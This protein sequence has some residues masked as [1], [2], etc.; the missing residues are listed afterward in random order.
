MANNTQQTDT[1]IIHAK[2]ISILS[3]LDKC[4]I[5]DISAIISNIVYTQY[6]QYDGV[7]TWCRDYYN[8]M[9][10]FPDEQYINIQFQNML[11]VQKPAFHKNYTQE[12]LKVLQA[13]ATT[14]RSYH[15]MVQG[16][17][18]EAANLINKY[19]AGTTKKE[20]QTA[21]SI[22][23]RYRILRKEMRGGAKSGIED[24]DEVIRY[25]MKKTLNVFVAPSS[26]F[27][28]TLAV[29][30]CYNMLVEQGLNVVYLTLEDNSDFI[31]YNFLCR[32]SYE[33]GIPFS[34]EEVKKYL[35]EENRLDDFDKVGIDFDNQIKGKLRIVSSE[36]IGDFNPM[37]IINMLNKI[38]DEIGNIDV[39]VVDHFNIMNDPI[40]GMQLR[41]PEL[42]AYYVR[43]MTHLA[44]TYDGK[45]FVLIGL[46][47]A[48]REGT[49]TFNKGKDMDTTQI[50]NTSE[51]ERSA[52][53]VTSLFAD[54]DLRS[55]GK[56]RLKILK[57]R[58][59]ER[60]KIIFPHCKPE[61]FKIGNS[62][63]RTLAAEEEINS[64]ILAVTPAYTITGGQ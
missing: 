50:A 34:G 27:K 53:I 58:L 49:S 12:V 3:N 35:M 24:Y 60:S 36:E 13:E 10:K 41:G 56:V 38:K 6:A 33:I 62:V 16:K 28:T 45:G 40:P 43:F 9:G 14:S 64:A 44:I 42:F 52:T 31:W 54:D 22:T 30:M 59:G 21:T 51:L 25:F 23:Q 37:N 15:M 20:L 32:H 17:Y 46:S 47:Q 48:N 61:Y 57:N 2:I 7:L 18:Q 26:N 8:A 55:Q 39:V 29:S 4:A 19:T 1:Q 63:Q 5:D 11:A